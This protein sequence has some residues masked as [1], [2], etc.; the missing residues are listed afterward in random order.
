M[1]YT[2]AGQMEVS[3]GIRNRGGQRFWNTKGPTINLSAKAI[4]YGQA[5][6]S[7]DPGVPLYET[8]WR[9]II[10]TRGET[11][12]LTFKSPGSASGYQIVFSDAL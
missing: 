1:R 6:T 8:N 5:V 9:K 10:L 3:I 2:D 7:A 4:F 12:Y 11:T